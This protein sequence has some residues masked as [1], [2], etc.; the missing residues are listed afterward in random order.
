MKSAKCRRTCRPSCCAFLNDGS[1][2][3]VGGDREVK[4]NVRILSATHRDLEKMVSEGAVPRRP[5]LP[6]QRAQRR[7]AAAART[8]SGHPAAGALFHAAGL[9]ADPAPGLPP[10]TRYLP[11]AARQS[12]A[13]QRAAIAERDLPRC[14]DLRK[15]PGGYRRSR[16][17]RHLRGAPDRQRCRQPR[18]GGR[19][20]SKKP[21][22]KSSTS[23][24][25]R[26]GNW[27]AACK[28][29][30]PRLPIACASTAFPTSPETPHSPVGAAAMR[31]LT[32]CDC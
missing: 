28:P 18:T 11:G 9:R 6:P 10:R 24:T 23:A 29:R 15:Q 20:S 5:V 13:G 31:S 26:P 30:T 14:G 8:R 32:G 25:P 1:F 27:P 4:V 19:A 3:R 7:S 2:R 16:H 22:W 21:C 17:R 12:L